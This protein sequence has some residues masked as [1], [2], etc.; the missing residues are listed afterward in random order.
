VAS[1]PSFHLDLHAKPVAARQARRFVTEHVADLTAAG[2]LALLTSE[3]V[4]N[5]VLHAR[6]HLRLG[7]TAGEDH[8]LVT[9]ADDDASGVLMVPP[10]DDRRPSGRGLLLVDSLASQWGVQQHEGGKTVWFTLPRHDG[11]AAG[12]GSR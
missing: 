3:V 5:G 4:T 11:A 9:C 6:T 12:G 8:I 1:D 7:V 2:T 10:P